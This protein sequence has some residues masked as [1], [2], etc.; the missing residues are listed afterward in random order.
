MADQEAPSLFGLC[1]FAFVPS[2]DLT[3]TVIDELSQSLQKYGGEV[4][5]RKRDGSLPLATITH[6]ISNTIEF[7]QYDAAAGMMIPVV[8]SKWISASLAK[9]KQAQIRPYTPDPRMIFSDIHL[10]CADIPER[11]QDAI[12]GASMAMGGMYSESVTRL[13]THICALSMDHPKVKMAVEKKHKCKIILPH[14]FDDCFKLGKR[15]DEGPYLLPDPEILRVSPDDS[16]EPQCSPYLDGATSARPDYIPPPDISEGRKLHLTIFN[17]KKIMI[18]KDLDMRDRLSRI[19]V[20]L[21]TAG[22]GQIT[23]SAVECDWLVCRYRDTDEYVMASQLGKT[24]GNMSWLFYL[25]QTNTW[26]NPLHRL[27]HYPE[28]RN[29][30]PGFQDM[31]IS[32]SN[33]GGE[34]RIYLENLIKSAGATFTK[35]M[36]ADNTHLVTARDNSEKCE[37]ARDW[38][39]NMVNHLWIEESYAKCE[40]QSLSVPKYTHFP[41]RTNLSE[42]IGQTFLDEN[43]LQALYFSGGPE[44]PTPTKSPAGRKRKALDITDEN[45][46]VD[47][48]EPEPEPPSTAGPKKSTRK[49][50]DIMRDVDDGENADAEAPLLKRPAVKASVYATPARNRH[51]RSGKENETP[52]TVTSS[53]RSAKD[54]ALGR[55]SSLAPD[56]ALY[57][58]EKKRSLKDGHGPWGGKR[59]ADLIER[60]HL[61]RRPAATSPA[62]AGDDKDGSKLEKRPAKKARPTLPEVETRVILTGFKRWVNDINKEEADRKKLRD[63]G[64][65]VVQDGQPCDYLVAPQLVRT[66][67]FL[68]NLSKGAVVLSSEWVEDCLDKKQMLDPDEYILKDKE[69]EKRFGMKLETSVRRAQANKGHLLSGI[70]IYCTAGIKNGTESYQAIAE[71]NGAIFMVYGPR[72]GST[73]R[74]TNPED[75]EGG[76]EPVYLLSTSTPDE[77]KLWKRFE[78]MARK[79][80]ME[81]RVVASDWLLD[82]V[83]KQEVGFEKKYLVNNFFI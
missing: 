49:T 5:A 9:N 80:N 76:P 20:D 64:I 51:V 71:A 12:V 35:T 22:G 39:I 38:N 40:L 24:V 53:G 16:I 72:S 63:M 37:A 69:N 3:D 41:P 14:W 26:S 75:D 66:V 73:I 28:P 57:E 30:I 29:G 47:G 82:V 36:K 74:P 21:I 52:S 78:D 77:K 19:V 61:N 58:K 25:I 59:A 79:G 11:D 4:C 6:I 62:A 7:P 32:V 8:K 60:E 55:L 34:A 81:P 10:S 50:F 2:R 42:I 44:K 23:D 56:I 65:A 15:I 70:P 17:E 45:S 31:R 83:M 27:L 68:R 13:T 46:T 54:K 18:S 33:Y 48:P 43:K 1:T 67:K